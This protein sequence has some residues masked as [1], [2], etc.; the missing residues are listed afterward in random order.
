MRETKDAVYF[1]G[2][3]LSQWFKS[4]FTENGLNFNTAEQYMMYHKAMLFNDRE[5]AEKIRATSDPKKQKA[6]G[7]LVKNFDP[8]VW[9]E[10]KLNIVTQG[11]YLKFSQNPSLK[12]DLLATG[13]KL[14]VEASPVDKVWGVGLH[15][16]DDLILDEK[17][18]KGEN[19]LGVA[20]M[21]TRT[22]LK[23]E[24]KK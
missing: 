24:A 4:T 2:S 19:L 22:R 15:Y 23:E 14:L 10:H 12:R 13:D 11:N 1:W 9:D 21:N 8:A 20:L 5:N 3:Y 16:D 6:F 18:W 7:R 17:N